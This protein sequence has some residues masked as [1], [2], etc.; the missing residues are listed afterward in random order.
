MNASVR[1]TPP[2]IQ[3]PIGGVNQITPSTIGS[4]I[5]A[6]MRRSMLKGWSGT[7]CRYRDSVSVPAPTGALTPP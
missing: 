3:V 2:R 6:L 1:T 5:S 4:R 7:A